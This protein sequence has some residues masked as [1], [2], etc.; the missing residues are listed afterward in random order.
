[1]VVRYNQAG[2]AHLISNT[3][4]KWGLGITD[5]KTVKVIFGLNSPFEEAQVPFPTKRLP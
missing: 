5:V 2:L 1:M 3:K 4:K